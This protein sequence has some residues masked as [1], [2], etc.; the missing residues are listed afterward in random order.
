MIRAFISHSSKQ[1]RFVKDLVESLGRNYFIVDCYDFEAGNKTIEEI[2][3]KIDSST[4]F[5]LFLSKESI[6]SDWVK[7]EIEYAKNKFRPD[8]YKYFWPFI[9]DSALTI[10]DCPKWIRE[11][12]CFNLKTFTSP[13]VLSRIIE[14]KFRHIIWSKDNR[15]KLID[16]LM[17]GRNVD[18]D[19]FEDIYQSARGMKTRSLV[20]SGRDGVGKDMFISKCLNKIGYDIETIPFSISLDSKEGIEDYIVQLNLILQTYNSEQLMTVLSKSTEDK[21]KYAVDMTNE[22]LSGNIVLTIID[23]LACVLPNRALADW[24]V[25]MIESPAFC[26]KLALFIKCR[27]SPNTFIDTDHPRFCHIHL[28]PLNSKDRKK[29]FYN[30][31]RLYNITDI[32][33]KDVSW[34]VEKLLLS[35]YQLVKAVEA[36]SKNPIHTVKRDIDNLTS[37]GD[38]R[39]QPMIDYFFANEIQR[40]ILVILSKMDFVSYDIF[41]SFF[42]DEIDD[43]LQEINEMMDYGIVTIFGPHEEFFRLDHYFSDYIKRCRITL[44]PDLESLFND[45]LEQKIS[46]S[47]DITEDASVYLYEKKRIIISGRG[48][49]SDFL[50]PSIVVNAVMDIYNKQEYRQVINVCDKV[51]SDVHNYFL[52][53][54]RELRYWLCLSLARIVDERFYD[55]IKWFSKN[56]VEYYFLRGFYHRNAM[57]YAQAENFFNEA[58][59]KSPNLQRAKREKVTALL[60]QKKFDLALE[61][62]EE[63]YKN[64]PEN[65]YQIYGYFRC[66]VRKKLLSKE[67]KIILLGLM[68]SMKENLSEKHEELYAAMDI[69][70]QDYVNHLSPSQLI[71]VI[72][73]AEKS[74][75]NSI[76]VKR[77]AQTFKLRQSIIQKEQFFSEDC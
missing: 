67:D 23:N 5:I 17:V 18:I 4:V 44:P 13:K 38:K 65:S 42:K 9:I 55:E 1:K 22:L 61:L 77:A 31:M 62:A 16:T 40:N 49:V 76:N 57:E 35:P 12:E 21:T 30:L 24:L 29:L 66:L 70:F 59:K 63:N 72:S 47:S 34:F 48:N 52:D 58:L 19:K 75:P 53:Q 60:A 26:N 32:S 56:D 46:A 11:E 50:I 10:E 2:Y 71:D 51:L 54:E 36:L 3:N 14:Q 69:E 43:V 37:W 74:F 45:I 15:R 39:I 7:D 68:N 64:S 28:D 73:K 20:V 8:N 25:D 41:E 6:N 27:K 33:D